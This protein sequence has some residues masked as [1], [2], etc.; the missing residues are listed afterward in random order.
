MAVDQDIRLDIQGMTCASCAMRI[1]KK[2]NKIDGVQASVNYALGTASV[3]APATVP[4]DQL[5]QTVEAAGYNASLPQPAAEPVDETAGLRRRLIIT[6][7]MALP[8]IVLSM[9]PALQFPGWQW[10]ALALTVPVVLWGGLGF[11]QAAWKNLRHRTATMDTLVSVG[12]LA[13]LAW[14]IYAMVFG[15]AGM[16]GMH[17]H[18]S[19]VVEPQEAADAIYLEAAAGVT[20]FLLL[21]RY[22]EARSKRAAGAA[23]QGLLQLKAD[24]VLVERAGV[25]TSIP[26]SEL[27]IGDTFRVRPGDR[28][29]TDGV[30][31]DG[32]ASI[33]ASAVTGESVPIEVGSGDHVVGG[34]LAAGGSLRVRATAV[35]ADTELSRIAAL[36]E[37]AQT[38]KASV[39]RL[40]DKVAGVFVPIIL[41]LA[42]ATLLGWWLIGGD[43]TRG[44]TAAVAVL[45]IA[46]P[47]ALGLATPVA[48][49]VGTGRGAQLGI[50]IRGP[51]ALEQADAIQTVVL[52]K[53][54]TLT[55]GRMSLVD[56]WAAD[57]DEQQVRRVAATLEQGSAHPIATAIC[58]D[59]TDLLP[60]RDFHSYDG[61]GVGG[62]VEGRS[63]L[64]GR[65]SWLRDQGIDVPAL[66]SDRVDAQAGLGRTAV[67]LVVD[68]QVSGVLSVA[69]RIRATSGQAVRGFE[70]LGLH[71]VMMTGDH[72]G[73]ADAV[74]R[75]LGI[76][77]VYAEVRPQDKAAHISTL[78]QQ[79]QKVAMVGDGV[80]DAAA[81]ATADLGIAMGSG[82]DVASD[83][84]DLTLLRTD[85]VVAV[86]AVRLSRATLR[87]I[88]QNIGWAFAYNLAAVPLAMSGRL[89]PMVAGFAMAAS[90]VLVVLNSLRLRRFR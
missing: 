52:D 16:I 87:V 28:V 35:G 79:G 81:L 85:P 89:G 34:T 57:G 36:V 20:A 13:A 19:V 66:V 27:V 83:A 46:C 2:L 23:V 84:A 12:T 4:V 37:Q 40:A 74:A 54:G 51:Q 88:R 39:Q 47:C 30:V 38:G 43:L 5:V 58:R 56:V 49:L 41:L 71:P 75:Q 6:W 69:D 1:E 60:V 31:I 17:H 14:S 3:H 53:T 48:L 64:L 86:D 22:L 33:D 73:V 21:G 67:V 72:Q 32:H 24:D 65:V 68:G 77:E 7:I 62:V 80:N 63:A 50:L 18:F 9:V 26:L 44:F 90:S 8:V 78:Q 59:R 11:H 42:L 25:A 29:A 45:V 61:A 70:A 55:D 82:A 15:H 10:V 76:N